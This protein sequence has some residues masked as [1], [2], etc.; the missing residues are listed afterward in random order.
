MNEAARSTTTGA[1]GIEPD[2]PASAGS[3]PPLSPR[4]GW[5][6]RSR[7]P[8]IPHPRNTRRSNAR[9]ADE[10]DRGLGFGSWR[11]GDRF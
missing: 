8:P 5:A 6:H 7:T 3:A 10:D 4:G 11:L 9:A 1:P 2:N